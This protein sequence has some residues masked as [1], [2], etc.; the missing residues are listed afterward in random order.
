[1]RTTDTSAV[2]AA[3]RKKTTVKTPNSFNLTIMSELQEIM[4]LV[5]KYSVLLPCRIAVLAASNADLAARKQNPLKHIAEWSDVISS[6]DDLGQWLQSNPTK[7]D[8]L[9]IPEPY[10]SVKMKQQAAARRTNEKLKKTRPDHW[11]QASKARWTK[12][13]LS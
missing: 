11:R 6:P 10:A 9:I 2:I 5:D 13:P 3:Q 4:R 7:L 12:P 8:I 1:M